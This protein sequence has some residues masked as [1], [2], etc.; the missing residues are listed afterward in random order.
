MRAPSFWKGVDENHMIQTDNLP[1]QL[2]ETGLFCCWR[3]EERDGKKTKVPYNPRT[4]GKAQSTN[5]STFAPLAVA[6]DALERGGFSGIGVG[7]F[8]ALGA[9]DIDHCVDDAG[10]LSELAFDVMETMQ[11]YTENSPSGKGLRILFTVPEGFSYDKA[12]YY[13]NNQRAGLEVYIAGCTQ[14]YV[15]VTGAA[16]TPGYPLEERGEQLRAVLEKYM[17]R[18]RAQQRP[19]PVTIPSVP[20]PMDWSAEIG[21]S[22]PAGLDDQA[23]LERARRTRNGTQFTALWAGDTTGYKSASEADIALCNMLA[24]WTGKDAARMDRLFRQSGLFR[25][26]KWDRPTAGST[27]GAITVQ[28]AIASARQTYDPEARSATANGGTVQSVRPPDYSDAGNAVVFTRIYQDSL[29]FVDAL[30]WLCWNGQRWERGDHH[31]VTWALDLSAQM[32]KEAGAENRDALLKLAEAQAGFTETGEDEDK[33]ALQAAK[34]AAAKAKAYLT[35]A[36]NLRGATRLRNMMDLSI[37]ALVLKADKLDANPFDLNTPGGIVNLTTGQLRP[38]DRAAYCSQITKTAPGDFGREMWKNFL[39]TT[40][41][42]DGSIQGFLQMVSGMALIGTVYQEGIVIACGGGRNGK[43]TF[44]NALSLALGDYAGSIDIKTMTTDRG[45]KSASLATLR[46]KRLV[47]TGELE[48]HQRLSIATLKQVA[49]TDKLTIEEKYKQPETVK[50]S[51]TLVLFTNHLPRVGSTD[52]GTWRRLLVVP[53]NA[54]IPPGKGVQ[55]FA[56]VLVREA[57]GAILAWAIE[58]AVNFVR[59]GFKLEIPDVVAMATEDYRQREDWLSNFISERCVRGPNAREGA[60][61]LYLEYRAWAEESGEYIRRENDFSA[62]MEQAGYRRIQPKGK[63]HYVGLRIDYGAKV[64]NR[65]AAR[66]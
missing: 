28:N 38:H 10:E 60:R 24:F 47:V 57:G 17:V 35:H 58:G 3:Y 46:G 31:A 16:L 26:G 2:R 65:C 8:G 15:T 51:H 66:V 42:G 54:V 6:L 23:L 53:F 49:S 9:I 32:L 7:I 39:Q 34:D 11:A 25:P 43:S 12:R 29:I 4:G 27:Y 63:W 52:E 45:N 30:G 41:C 5:P 20:A 19:T 55:N 36:K 1:A 40:T 48:E 18:D 22:G 61:A 64:E 56:E 14:K 44:F 33:E 62:A 37:P 13:I 50:Q 59:N 21:G